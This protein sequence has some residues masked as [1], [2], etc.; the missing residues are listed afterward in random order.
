[1]EAA[2]WLFVGGDVA[3][4]SGGRLPLNHR[5]ARGKAFPKLSLKLGSGVGDKVKKSI[6]H[7]TC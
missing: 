1:M 6:F 4:T 3:L 5:L 7:A 2:A